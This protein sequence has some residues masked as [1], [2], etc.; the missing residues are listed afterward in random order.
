MDTSF[1]DV[2][3]VDDDLD[4]SRSNQYYL[5]ETFKQETSIGT[6]REA[7]ILGTS[8]FMRIDVVDQ[9][10]LT[11]EYSKYIAIAAI[12]SMTPIS[13]DTAINLV[14][15]S[16]P[17]NKSL[18]SLAANN[19]DNGFCNTHTDKN[20]IIVSNL[21]DNGSLSKSVKSVVNNAKESLLMH[22]VARTRMFMS[23][24]GFL[25]VFVLSINQN[26]P[27]EV[28]LAV[29]VAPLTILATSFVEL[30]VLD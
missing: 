8:R 20:K 14:K 6:I 28:F 27:S 9:Y 29:S 23:L 25:A 10:G 3:L 5:I 4:L 12:A 21:E 2:L 19:N 7:N 11:T 26:L 13:K 17:V 16:K 22:R 1:E 15:S 24:F 18:S 30:A